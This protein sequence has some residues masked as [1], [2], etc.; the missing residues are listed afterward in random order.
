MARVMLN[1]KKL[2]SRI[3]AEAINIACYTINRLYLRPSTNK[4]PHELRKCR[5]PN[6]SYF[7]VLGCTYYILNGQEQLGKFQPKSD[8][9]TSEEDDS[10]SP[11]EGTKS[12]VQ[13]EL[14]THVVAT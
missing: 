4:T 3:Y 13:K 14:A 8:H 9:G 10:I 12:Q 1:S 7:H 11:I 2:S 5:K 6:L